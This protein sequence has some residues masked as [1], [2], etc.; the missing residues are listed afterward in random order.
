MFHP[1]CG[2]A[3]TSELKLAKTF[4]GLNIMVEQKNIG[5][6]R[7]TVKPIMATVV[8]GI[9]WPQVGYFT[10]R[11]T[12]Q[13]MMLKKGNYHSALSCL[14]YMHNTFGKSNFKN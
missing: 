13:E 10:L 9:K 11:F 4:G 5:D 1:K 7:K 12:M 14:I 8:R 6:G 2:T 3:K